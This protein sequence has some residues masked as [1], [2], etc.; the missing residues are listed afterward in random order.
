[1]LKTLDAVALLRHQRHDFTNDLQVL[2]GYLELGQTERAITFLRQVFK[3]LE[4]ERQIFTIGDPEISIFLYR[5][6][7]MARER[8]VNIKYGDVRLG[9]MSEHQL[10]KLGEAILPYYDEIADS[11]GAKYE[12]VNASV[13][14]IGQ[15]KE[16]HFIF[17]VSSESGHVKREIVLT[18]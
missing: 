10:E 11:T 8:G 12:D 6:L 15:D 18:R 16:V 2:G 1:M 4:E 13:D 3:E 17:N 5:Q 14:I 7:L 9:T